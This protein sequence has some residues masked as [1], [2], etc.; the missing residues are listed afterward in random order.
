M[1]GGGI[2]RCYL[3]DPTVGRILSISRRPCGVTHPK[4]EE[5]LLPDFCTVADHQA[6]FATYDACLHCM[7]VSAVG[8]TEA[9]YTTLTY[10]LTLTLARAVLAANPSMS[11]CYVSGKGTNSSETGGQMWARVKGRTEN[12]LLAMPFLHVHAIR[13]GFIKPYPGIKA[14]TSF[15]NVLYALFSPIVPLL[16]RAK[17]VA[18][19]TPRLAAAMLAGARGQFAEPVMESADINALGVG[20]E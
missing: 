3:D 7:G 10:N 9:Q 20:K 6:S 1:V 17:N 4:L 14:A 11:F 15:Y 19:T 12:A 18:T 2:L 16:L 5:L 13:P 8:L